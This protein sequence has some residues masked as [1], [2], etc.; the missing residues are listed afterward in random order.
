MNLNKR[1][2]ELQ[3]KAESRAK[4]TNVVARDNGRELIE[5]TVTKSNALARG[6]YRFSKVEKRVMESL[7]SQLHPKMNDTDFQ[8]IKLKATDYAKTFNVPQKH[9]YRDIKKAIDKLVSFVIETPRK[10]GKYRKTPL[11]AD[12]FYNEHEGE[13]TACFNPRMVPHLKGLKERFCS[14]ALKD[15]VEFKSTYTWRFY[16]ILVSWNKSKGK[17]SGGFTIEV[18]ELRKMLGVPD[19]YR[20]DNI[21]KRVLNVATAELKEKS[22]IKLVVT[23]KDKIRKKI[24]SL[25]IT[26][27]E[28]K[29]ADPQRCPDT[30]D[31]I[32]A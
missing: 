29:P 30:I 26:F 20:W 12:A 3:K 21:S 17:F 28:I 18:E 16:E 15:A 2:S 32:E 6:Y 4:N 5:N 9:A 10:E 13:I 27:S 1:I 7:V 24:V 22:N 19:S 11:M 14:Y 23:P 8:D 25:K 31:F